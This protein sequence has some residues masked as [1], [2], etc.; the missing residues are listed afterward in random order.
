[1]IYLEPKTLGWRPL[2]TSFLHGE[3]YE[4][5]REFSKE[6]NTLIDWMIDATIDHL[7]HVS[8]V[9]FFFLN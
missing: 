2:V 5:L 4:P 6:F 9:L 7:R 3:F 1:M 8:K